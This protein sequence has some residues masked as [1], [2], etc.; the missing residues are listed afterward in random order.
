MDSSDEHGGAEN[1]LSWDGLGVAVLDAPALLGNLE[2]KLSADA[3]IDLRSPLLSDLAGLL[4]PE[5]MRRGVS[6]Y[7]IGSGFPGP[8]SPQAG[9]RGHLLPPFD[10]EQLREAVRNGIV[11]VLGHTGEAIFASNEAQALGFSHPVMIRL[12]SGDLLIDAGPTGPMPLL[13]MIPG[14]PM[15]EPIGFLLDEPFT[16]RAQCDQLSRALSRLLPEARGLSLIGG[17][18][19]PLPQ[20]LTALPVIDDRI[21]G[22]SPSDGS[23]TATLTI[24][25]WGLP[26]AAREN[27]FL[28]AVDLGSRDGIPAAARPQLL[29]A[30]EAGRVVEVGERRLLV[31]L[32]ERPVLPSPWPVTLLGSAGA[33]T[34]SP[35][36]WPENGLYE[37]IWRL[38]RRIPFFLRG[39][40]DNRTGQPIR[41]CS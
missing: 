23:M 5:W 26:T 15:I 25:V 19:G 8:N 31:E 35:A 33:A 4:C 24:R 12:R 16:G 39:W 21:L 17:G 3:L 18:N 41:L 27:S 2:K 6:G 34:V 38:R 7:L 40:K 32:S 28:V 13:E 9:F 29:V 37:W 14:L 10:T 36:E 11:P 22:L 1:L 20:R 30:G